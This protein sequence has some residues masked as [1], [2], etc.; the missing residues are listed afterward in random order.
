MARPGTVLALAAAAFAAVWLRFYPP[1]YLYSDEA[2]NLALAGVLAKGTC[3][4]DVAGRH[5][6][7]AVPARDGHEASRYPPGLAALLAPFLAAGTW[8]VF[9]LPLLTHLAVFA[10]LAWLLRRDGTSPLWALLWLFYPTAALHSRVLMSNLP[11]ALILLGAFALLVRGGR[12]AATAAGLLAGL[13]LLVRPTLAVGAAALAVGALWRGRRRVLGEASLVR[14]L[15]GA[16]VA[17]FALGALAGLAALGACNLHVWGSALASGYGRVGAVE[18]FSP[19]ALGRNLPRY[20]LC[21]LLVYPLMLL[22]PFL[23]RGRWG[24]EKLLVPAGFLALYGAYGYFDAGASLPETLVRAPRFLLA[25]V[26]FLLLAYA[27]AL[28]GR[29]RRS[30][31]PGLEGAALAAVLALGLGGTWALFG[32]HWRAQRRQAA[33]RDELYARTADGALLVAS[34]ETAELVQDVWGWGRREVLDYAALR[35]RPLRPEVAAGRPVYLVT[36]SKPGT[37]PWAAWDRAVRRG[38]E[39]R[40]ALS[41]G[42]RRLDGWRLGVWRLAARSERAGGEAAGP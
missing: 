21:L 1:M 25:A 34:I 12:T 5:L 22:A 16:D 15:A 2:G 29:L 6:P 17:G 14:G 7:E 8:A 40:F 18:L 26:P 24:L 23:R 31:I 9:L 30:G 13:G 19:A 4:A 38:L 3:F 20:G 33:A 28:S 35:R 36:L 37:G 10:L 11:E 27:G 39:A 42:E 32:R 41:G